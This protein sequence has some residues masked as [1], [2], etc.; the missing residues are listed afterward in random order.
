ME[1]PSAS[2]NAAES[3]KGPQQNEEPKFQPW[4]VF[5][6]VA[7]KDGCAAHE[8][9]DWSVGIVG[10][11]DDFVDAQ[12]P[13]DLYPEDL[14]YCGVLPKPLTIKAN[15]PN[16]TS[17]ANRF[18][19]PFVRQVSQVNKHLQSKGQRRQTAVILDRASETNV[20][21][22]REKTSLS[23]FDVS[24]HPQCLCSLAPQGDVD[25]DRS[26]PHGARGRGRLCAPDTT[27]HLNPQ[28]SPCQNA[29]TNNFPNHCAMGQLTIAP[30]LGSAT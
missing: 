17:L 23:S 16:P 13:V 8:G 26:L 1:H 30:L 18:M 19:L 24:V 6:V 12:S 11:P 7:A 2:G 22:R 20:V 15:A 14:A 4:V 5:G 27:P 21:L 3:Q 29:Q 25:A 28:P 9:G 10:R